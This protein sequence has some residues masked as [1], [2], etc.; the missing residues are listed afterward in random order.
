MATSAQI[1]LSQA[2]VLVGLPMP[3]T[4]RTPTVLTDEEIIQFSRLNRP[5]RV[6]L[7]AQG[8]LEI[9][10]PLG[11][12]G[13]QREIFVGARLFE[14]AE[15]NGGVV[16][17]SNVGF[18]LP[19]GSVRSPDA[20]WVCDT[21]YQSLSRE[22]RRRFAPVCPDFLIELLSETDSRKTLEAKM[23]MWIDKGAQLAWMIDPYAA[24]I[25]IYRPGHAPELLK[26]PDS[27]S[28]GHPVAGFQLDMRALWDEHDSSSKS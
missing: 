20:A 1:D 28:A 26:R 11:F 13:A 27:V 10:S 14:W 3:V 12:D 23:R 6:E 5:Y 18:R 17:S 7:N 19:D 16:L 25:T 9:M 24:E 2:E 22:E 21:H 8:E 4:L 15:R